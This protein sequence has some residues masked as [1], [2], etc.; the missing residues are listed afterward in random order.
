MHIVLLL[1]MRFSFPLWPISVRLT[2]PLFPIVENI[3]LHRVKFLCTGA[4]LSVVAFS[5][6]GTCTSPSD[7]NLVLTFL[8]SNCSIT[9]HRPCLL[10]A[11]TCI[12]LFACQ[13]R[14]RSYFS[15][16]HSSCWH[17]CVTVQLQRTRYASASTI[18][19]SVK[20]LQAQSVKGSGVKIIPHLFVFV[21]WVDVTAAADC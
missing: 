7:I 17:N 1:S 15:I 19:E 12:S 18:P 8:H 16:L 13:W 11:H 20:V 4:Q 14:K 2:F 3:Q 21:Q 5:V 6:K 10:R 9:Q